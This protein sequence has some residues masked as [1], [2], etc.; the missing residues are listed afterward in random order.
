MHTHTFVAANFPL[1]V[2][3]R[4]L[5]IS[6][7]NFLFCVCFCQK[8][9][10][11]CVWLCAWIM[12]SS[13]CTS[14]QVEHF[15]ATFAR[16]WTDRILQHSWAI[17]T[18][19]NTSRGRQYKLY[20]KPVADIPMHLQF[21]PKRTPSSCTSLPGSPIHGNWRNAMKTATTTT[22]LLKVDILWRTTT[23]VTT[24]AKQFK[25]NRLRMAAVLKMDYAE[26]EINF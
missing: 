16:I 12:L 23:T 26:S 8:G 13:I 19:A 21:C 7:S 9:F 24:T 5:L 25:I 11:Y 18:P 20:D 15:V 17:S 4:R 3:A 22:K 6:W 10:V 1:F 2:Y 14:Q